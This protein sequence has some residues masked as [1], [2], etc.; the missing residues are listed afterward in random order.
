MATPS[1]II[2]IGPER[3]GKSTVGRLLAEKLGL[4]FTLVSGKFLRIVNKF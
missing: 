1:T 4:P 2:L 3:T